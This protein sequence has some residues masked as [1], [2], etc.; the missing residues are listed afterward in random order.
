MAQPSNEPRTGWGVVSMT[1]PD[2]AETAF[3]MASRLNDEIS[4]RMPYGPRGAGKL[5]PSKRKLLLTLT[6]RNIGLVG[7]RTASGRARG[8]DGFPSA[9]SAHH[10]THSI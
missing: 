4:I 9:I 10:I 5:L 1:E 2:L 8:L 7:S 3:A 6:G